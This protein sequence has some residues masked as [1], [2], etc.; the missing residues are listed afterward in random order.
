MTD[1]LRSA[2]GAVWLNHT[3]GGHGEPLLLLH[4]L[5]GSLV[6]WSPV[7]DRLAA[8]REVIAID[9]PG[10]GESNP[11]PEGVAPRAAN[12]A[13]AVLDFFDAL[14]IEGKPAIAGISLGG[15]VA[16]ESARQGGASAV[17]ALCPAGFWRR[18]PDPFNPRIA[19]R[20]RRGRALLPFVR[21]VLQTARGR[22]KTL[23]RF[24]F[25]P[26]RLSP[27]EAN[28]IAKAYVT[29]PA[30][31]EAS[32]LMRAGRIEELKAIKVPI[33]LAWAEHDTLVRNKPLPE[34]ALP[35]GVEQVVLPGCGHVPT[36]D[37]PDLVARVI[38]AG[39]RRKR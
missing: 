19:R 29:A 31:D 28:A 39:A 6:Q 7:I 34:K 18:S 5:G 36:W 27:G 11:L 24:V 1:D 12:L 3:R 26:E 10:F 9:M 30:Y 17:V 35:K 25:R 13:T 2:V 20:R 23:G 15:W 22:R 21:P 4:S 14:G 38:L 32:A 8:E 16:I 37:D 33:T